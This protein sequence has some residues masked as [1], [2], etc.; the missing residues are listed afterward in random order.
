MH[1]CSFALTH[2]IYIHISIIVVGWFRD[3]VVVRGG[4]QGLKQI[5]VTDTD[6]CKT[7]HP[8][9]QMGADTDIHWGG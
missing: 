4:G 8:R 1:T 2:Y 9:I 7:V 6:A 5:K 3:E